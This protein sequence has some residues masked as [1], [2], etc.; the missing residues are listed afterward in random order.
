MT[1]S[2]QDFED[3]PEPSQV[4]LDPAVTKKLFRQWRSPR[5]GSANPERMNNPVWEWAL[6]S[7]MTAY[8]LSQWM[9][10]P[11]ALKAGP[12][13]CFQRNGP[14]STTLADGRI[15]LIGGE[16]EDSY[17]PDFYI[18][19][20]VVVRH[21]DDRLDIFGY[22]KEVFPPT[23]F[24]S[25]T[26]VGGKIVV[27]GGLGHP[28][29]REAGITPVFVLDLNTLAIS[30][31]ATSGSP[32]GWIHAHAASLSDDGH[33]ILL[34][35]GKIDGGSASQSLVRNIDDWRLDLASWRWERL[36]NR[37]WQQWE[38][39]RQ[40]GEFV[41]LMQIQQAVLA[42]DPALGKLMEESQ[43]QLREQFG[44][45]TLEEELGR[46]PDL[47]LAARL[48]RPSVEHEEMPQAQD[49]YGVRRIKVA[50]VVVRYE[51]DLGGVQVMVEGVL[52]QPTIDALMTDLRD[53]LAGFENCACV[54]QRLKGNAAP[55][56]A[57]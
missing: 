6:R 53:K 49:E 43:R 45:P 30:T 16:H 15:V 37:Q 38:V 13:W 2:P 40:D 41:H 22:P 5:F 12:G 14:S 52:P 23:D 46:E 39:R 9:G 55:P 56:A 31:V 18:Y 17:D 7:G 10:G 32:P 28:E 25:A 26:L 51:E 42:R 27:M 3:A 44:L 1:N 54:A 48:Y 36:T 8:G 29:E 19:N 21:P 33:F 34:Q 11:S 20:D 35:G 57:S 50:G 47:G 24:H 4:S